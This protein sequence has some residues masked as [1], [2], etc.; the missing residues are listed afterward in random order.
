MTGLLANIPV[1]VQ[2]SSWQVT[3][4]EIMLFV[5]GGLFTLGLLTLFG[6][7]LTKELKRDKRMQQREREA[8]EHKAER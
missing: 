6:I 2:Q 3:G 1:D 5:I 4:V 7:V 8:R